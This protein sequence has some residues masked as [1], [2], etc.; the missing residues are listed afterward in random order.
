M[1]IKR[2]E[3]RKGKDLR[4]GGE[5]EGEEEKGRLARHHIFQKSGDTVSLNAVGSD[6]N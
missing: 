4:G 6:T 3:E 5:I 1:E 2:E